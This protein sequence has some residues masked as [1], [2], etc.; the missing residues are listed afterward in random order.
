MGNTC[1]ASSSYS[2]SGAGGGDAHSLPAYAEED[3]LHRGSVLALSFCG[4]KTV[5]CSDDG[6]ICIFDWTSPR[7][8]KLY[9][10]PGHERAV[11][12]VAVV[13]D[14]AAHPTSLWSVSRD[15]SLR[16]W[17]A[18]T[19]AALQTIEKTHEL[20]VSALAVIGPGGEG[21]GAAVF[22][23]SRDYHVKRWDVTTGACMASF[24]CPRNIVTALE[25]AAASST[26]T[27]ALLF[28]SSEDLCVRGWDPRAA[29]ASVPALHLTGFVYF[30]LCLAAHPDG[31]TL[32]TGC[33]GFNSVGC[34]VKLWDV[35]SAAQP[36]AVL[37][38]HSQ[39][40]TGVRFSPDGATL[41]S[42]CKGGHVHAWSTAAAT[43]PQSSSV[44]PLHSLD[45][46]GRSFSA[47]ALAR[48][49]AAF[50]L[51]AHDGSVSLLELGSEGKMRIVS[52]TGA[53]NVIDGSTE[54]ALA[55]AATS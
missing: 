55:R 42:A 19:G 43:A 1:K 18:S 3:V 25:P 51:G 29:S 6:R 37:P 15:L 40:V 48:G 36:L 17:D 13:V 46:T 33:K 41:V 54:D 28:Q 50:A 26:S 11:N 23:G 16:Q 27:A 22:T 9:C 31:H 14:E 47:L 44:G 2:A 8:T 34:D 20:N 32:A 49:G 35:R 21:A 45:P 38:G 4:D 52:E 30:P 12:R 24:S 39:D 53:G 10:T 7:Q 5:S